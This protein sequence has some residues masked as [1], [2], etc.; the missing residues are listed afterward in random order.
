[1]IVK[2]ESKMN[3]FCVYC[4]TSY[5]LKIKIKGTLIEIIY[6]L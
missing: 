5:I 2:E 6:N 1:M 3:F 4:R